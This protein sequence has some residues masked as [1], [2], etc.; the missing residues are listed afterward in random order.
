MKKIVALLFV[1]VFANAC[2]SAPPVKT[3]AYANL[4]NHRTFEYD[5]PA[6]WKGIEA[7]FQNT[8]ITE[9][10]PKE[11]NDLEMRSITRR[12]L[13]TD[14]SYGQSRDKYQEYQ[15]NGT[16][17]KVWLQER[18]RYDVDARRVMGGVDVTVVAEEEIES[19]KTDGTSAGFH[20]V[21]N[22]DTSRA[23]EILNKINAAILAAPPSGA[24]P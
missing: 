8:K 4:P 2:S 5:F 18:T 24:A 20:S 7:T 6:V 16:P 21:D 10:K 19:L 13:Q 12:T 14:W 23:N 3:E 15:V 17:R 22:P 11:V 9:R 1:A